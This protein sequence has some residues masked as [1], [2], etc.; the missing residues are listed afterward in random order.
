MLTVCLTATIAVMYWHRLSVRM[1]TCG[2]VVNDPIDCR[3]GGPGPL[4]LPPG[5]APDTCGVV[6]NDPIDCSGGWVFLSQVYG[7]SRVSCKK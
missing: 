5:H 3:G 6:V 4:G 1:Y 2:V 7:I